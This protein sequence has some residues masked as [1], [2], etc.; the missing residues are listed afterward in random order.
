MDV[1][2]ASAWTLRSEAITT[3]FGHKINTFA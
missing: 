3:T 1:T 2:G